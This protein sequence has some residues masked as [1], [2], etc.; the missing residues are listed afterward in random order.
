MRVG[1]SYG[2]M[3]GGQNQSMC[4]TTNEPK[5]APRRYF[6]PIDED[7]DY[8]N[9]EVD[10]FFSPI[11]D[12]YAD[13]DDLDLSGEVQKNNISLIKLYKNCSIF[14]YHCRMIMIK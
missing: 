9:E 14:N 10:N 2:E 13:F 3:D 5:M 1:E 7:N 8:S 11:A 12:D 6:S 4:Q